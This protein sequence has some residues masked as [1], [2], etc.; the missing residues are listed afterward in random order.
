MTLLC[1]G[2]VYSESSTTQG[3]YIGPKVVYYL[4]PSSVER[5]EKN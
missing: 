1:Q 2:A 5:V 3:D 4:T